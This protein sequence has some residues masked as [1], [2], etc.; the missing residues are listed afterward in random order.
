MPIP[1]RVLPHLVVVQSCL[2]FAGLEALLDGP[3]GSGGPGEVGEGNS[4]GS[5]G[6]VVGGLG[7]VGQAAP[8]EEP[9]LGVGV[10]G[11]VDACPS[12]AIAAITF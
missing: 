3:A 2:P 9:V 8:G 1:A 12:P 4:F 5:V 7:R 10:A 11:V 6:Q